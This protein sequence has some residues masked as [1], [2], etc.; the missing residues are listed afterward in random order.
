MINHDDLRIEAALVSYPLFPLPPGF[1]R[2][3]MAEIRS[4][5]MRFHLDFLDFA[6]PAFIAFFF[7]LLLF[8]LAWL[9]A[10]LQPH[11]L[12]RWQ[13]A[14]QLLLQRLAPFPH[15]SIILFALVGMV[16]LA[17]GLLVGVIL[18]AP[19]RLELHTDG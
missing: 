8:V 10:S 1:T 15:W 19:T 13:S 17:F 9:I 18:L 12:L 7:A 11:W 5:E 4:V 6:L 2:R 16:C 14:F 3:V